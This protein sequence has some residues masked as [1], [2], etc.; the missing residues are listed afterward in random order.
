MKKIAFTTLTII[1][2]LFNTKANAQD[3]YIGTITAVGFDFA[4]RGWMKCEG[5]LL[6]IA[7]NSALFSLLGTTYGGD[8]ISTFALPDFRG[9]VIGGTGSG[10]G[11]SAR[12]IGQTTG[13]ETNQLTV[14][15]LPSHS[16]SV[17]AVT[18]EGN[19]NTPEGNLPSNTKLLDKEYSNATANT[20]MNNAMIGATGSGSPVNNMQPTIFVTYI[21]CTEGIFPSR[22]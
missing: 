18:S 3:S 16:H 8:G 5:Q 17:A 14:S 15:Q 9:R 22:P 20:T 11:V 1:T 21:I 4:P 12:N 13:T 7:Q 19:Q 10:P 2:L 6:S